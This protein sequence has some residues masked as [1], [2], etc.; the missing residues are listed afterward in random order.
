MFKRPTIIRKTVLLV[1][2][3]CKHKFTTCRGAR[4]CPLLPLLEEYCTAAATAANSVASRFLN[5]IWY[6]FCSTKLPFFDLWFFKFNAAPP[7]QPPPYAFLKKKKSMGLIC[8]SDKPEYREI[9]VKGWTWVIVFLY[10]AMR[11][12]KHCSK[13]RRISRK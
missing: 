12:M 10:F 8:Y 1:S 6:S 5:A 3:S 11:R 13:V 7:P 4:G 9:G 2:F